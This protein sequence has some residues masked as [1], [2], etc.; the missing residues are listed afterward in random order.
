MKN[1]AVI[2]ARGGSKGIPNK[3]I[4]A[5]AGKPLIYYTIRA[6][7]M[8]S[9]EETWV[10]TNSIAIAEVAESYGAKI[11]MRPNELATDTASS[12]L[13]LQHFCQNVKAEQVVF[14]Q[15]TSPLLLS[16]DI[17]Y[18]LHLMKNY[19]SV[20]S[21][22]LEHWLPRWEQHQDFVVEYHWNKEH[23][24][25]RQDRRKLIVENGA[26]YI[27]R[28]QFILDQKLRYGGEIGF[29]EMPY[30]RSFQVDDYEDLFVIESILRNQGGDGV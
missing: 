1:V 24:P 2:L 23:R 3:N 9:V 12:E 15:P 11:L 26:F 22:Y 7:I 27:A 13:A 16:K 8:S 20:F 4:V 25:R 29:V 18:G 28:H 10:S 17:D 21:G 19:D 14:I 5:L 30:S 6:A